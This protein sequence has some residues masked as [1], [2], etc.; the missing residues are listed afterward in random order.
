MDPVTNEAADA[1][2]EQVDTRP[3]RKRHPVLSRV[4]LFGLGAVLI[5]LL[6][7]PYLE[8]KKDDARTELEGKLTAM[9][10][11]LFLGGGPRA[12]LQQVETDFLEPDDVP[13]DL[14]ARALRF[15]ALAK[16]RMGAEG[17]FDSQAVQVAFAQAHAAA[18]DPDAQRGLLL[19]AAEA[20]LEVREFDEART[21]LTNDLLQDAGPTWTLFREVFVAKTE[22]DADP[23]AAA[24][25]LDEALSAAL[26]TGD[27][28]ARAEPV[29]VGARTWN[30]AQVAVYATDQRI[31]LARGENEDVVR[32]F[33]SRLAP[34][35]VSD[36]GSAVLCAAGLLA[37]GD[38]RLALE[39]L[40]TA[41]RAD[42]EGVETN[43]AGQSALRALLQG[44]R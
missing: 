38:E 37:T 31:V 16:K 3:W 2:T 32:S 44:S 12:V 10:V 35:A 28:G 11:G 14:K 7:V 33:W 1:A 40:Q 30:L 15:A 5:A 13:A 43:L 4:L 20:H 26:G 21:F 34:L 19:E 42:P 17:G 27:A 23:G 9:E 29:F 36:G 8:R 22:A 18:K 41:R 25:R 6:V 24:A 39:V